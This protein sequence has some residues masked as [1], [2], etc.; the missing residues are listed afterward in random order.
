MASRTWRQCSSPKHSS[1]GVP[2]ENVPAEESARQGQKRFMD[3][4]ALFIAYA[5]AA[6]LI[7]PRESPFNH[8][9]PSA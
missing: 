5:Q 6:K 8:P 2:F 3:V 1:G 4:G 7:E 9:A